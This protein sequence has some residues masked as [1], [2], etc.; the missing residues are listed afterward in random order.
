MSKLQQLSKLSTDIKLLQTLWTVITQADVD[1]NVAKYSADLSRA[2]VESYG[3][4]TINNWDKITVYQ[5]TRIIFEYQIKLEQ[6]MAPM[7][8]HSQETVRAY[9]MFLNK[10]LQQLTNATPEELEEVKATLNVTLEPSVALDNANK[11]VDLAALQ[12]QKADFL[13]NLQPGQEVL[14]VAEGGLTYVKV[15]SVVGNR[16]FKAEITDSN[17]TY[18]AVVNP[19]VVMAIQSNHPSASKLQGLTKTYIMFDPEHWS[20]RNRIL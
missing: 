13:D 1:A 11:L 20:I 8:S 14:I 16:R 19:D 7:L 4:S 17:E 2:I 5:G 3:Y 10:Q 6:S 15:G 12:Q 9:V 18:E